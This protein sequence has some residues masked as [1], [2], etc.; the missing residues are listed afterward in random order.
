MWFRAN[1][2]N[3]ESSRTQS[4]SDLWSVLLSMRLLLSNSSF[5]PRWLLVLLLFSIQEE[6]KKC[7][8]K[9]VCFLAVLAPFK[10]FPRNICPPTPTAS[11]YIIWETWKNG[12][13]RHG[14]VVLA[15]VYPPLNGTQIE[16]WLLVVLWS[17]ASRLTSLN[18]I[19]LSC[20]VRVILV[21]T[22]VC[23]C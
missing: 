22:S 15:H 18:P 19:F 14:V 17:W 16:F 21:S 8:G 5:G 4:P 11:V 3:S 12:R 10:G 2:V 7:E 9:M 6:E 13:V 1:I 20:K 23:C